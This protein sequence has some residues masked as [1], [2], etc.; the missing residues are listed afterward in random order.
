MKALT[1]DGAPDPFFQRLRH[2]PSRSLLIDY[3]GTLAPFANDR[4]R[5]LPSAGV[6][7][8]LS[9]ILATQAP[10][11]AVVFG[12]PE[13]DLEALLDIEP[14]PELWGSHGLEHRAADGSSRVR[15][16]SEAGHRV[17][18][19]CNWLAEQGW[20]ALLERKPLGLAL[21][22]RRAEP[23]RYETAKRLILERWSD[24]LG[25]AGLIPFEFDGGIEWR[26]GGHK[27]DVVN[28]VV[29]DMPGAAFASRRRPNQRGR[30]HCAARP[31]PRGTGPH[32]T[33]ADRRRSLDPPP[34]GVA[35][36][37]RKVGAVRPLFLSP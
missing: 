1:P 25:A 2:A 7:E 21:H 18:G 10:R 29:A 28:A 9:R 24:A 6:R 33:A 8:A 27:G 11:L 15:P 4:Q 16:L 37:P 19:V 35:S 26:P 23:Q 31:R 17:A 5:A 13:A 20:S 22:W 3:D 30:L 36:I 14:L 34:G 12:R 32:R